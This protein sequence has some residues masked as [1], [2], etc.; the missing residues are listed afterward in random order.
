MAIVKTIL[1]PQESVNDEFIS[2]IS[3]KAK[4][5]DFV[6]SDTI[7]AEFETSKAL[8]EIRS[9][10]DGYIKVFV[11]ENSDIKVGSVMFELHD[12]PVE[13]NMEKGFDINIG[14]KSERNIDKNN[15]TLFSNAALE[16]IEKYKIDI[17][18]LKHLSHV[19][20]KD[21]D[22]KKNQDKKTLNEIVHDKNKVINP[23]DKYYKELSKTKKR[24]YE[25][26][27]NVNSSSVISRLS[28]CIISTKEAIASSQIFIKSTP[29]PIIAFEVS[30]L[31]LKYPNLNSFYANGQQAIYKNINIGFA[32]DDGITGLKVATILE[33]NNLNLNSIENKITELT[34]KY[35]N[36]KLSTTELSSSTFTISDLF[37]SNIVSFHPLV[38]NNN[39][40]IL[41]ISSIINNQFVIDLSFD[42][43]I[44]S[45]KEVSNFLSDLKF[46]LETRF[47]KISHKQEIA[48][49]NIKCIK[50]FRELH[51]DF[52]GN[53]FF[54]KVINSRLNGYICSNCLNGW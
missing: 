32:L 51:E 3:I 21:L 4:N 36:N 26:L 6:K 29:L 49:Q 17:N 45:G 24:E 37:N 12:T 47:N 43:R 11:S 30:R 2:L 41:G 8:V 44:T 38:N 53:L 40:C 52:D 13:I 9:E 1:A 48:D 20:S 22:Q 54:Q 25:Y 5:G 18:S 10:T 35:P 16:Y 31:L 7:I 19:T 28:T 46:R 15:F 14:S 27:Y 42:H 23:T 34:L 50:C 39:S 33:T